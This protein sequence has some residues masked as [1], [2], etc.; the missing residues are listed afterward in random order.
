MSSTAD[1]ADTA[2]PRPTGAGETTAESMDRIY[3]RQRHFYDATRKFFLLGRDRLIRDLCPPAGGSVLEI[4]CGTGRNL[5]AAARAYPDARLFGLD[6][7]S[8]MLAT[9]RGKIRSAELE[10]R[11]VLGCGDAAS[12]DAEALFGRP[13]FDRVFLS[14]SISMIPPWHDALA[15]ALSLRAPEDGRLLIVDF[16]QQERLPAWFRKALRSWLIKFSVD[17]R[18]K[19]ES[20]LRELARPGDTIGFDTLFR[21]YAWYA[22]AARPGLAS[23]NQTK[24]RPPPGRSPQGYCL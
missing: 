11:I 20:A 24:R 7:S 12:F 14:Y 3:E 4:G 18:E 17:P 8:M 9:A 23:T 22:Q 5:V 19:L 16:G 6:V 21:G 1:T 15:L 10:H 2:P 13:S